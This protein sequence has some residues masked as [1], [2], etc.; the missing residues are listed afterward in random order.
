MPI[1]DSD[2]IARAEYEPADRTLFLRFTS[3]EWYAY[4]DVPPLTFRRLLAADSKGAFF[5]SAIR[6]RFSF[7]RLEPLSRP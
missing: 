6:D 3:G 5:Q 1:V 2:A 7:V 4:L